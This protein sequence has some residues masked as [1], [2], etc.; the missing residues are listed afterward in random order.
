MRTYCLQ[1]VSQKL[2][3]SKKHEQ[4]GR[5]CFYKLEMTGKDL[6]MV[7]TEADNRAAANH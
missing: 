5:K 7:A 4:W 6:K 2:N 1:K 3:I